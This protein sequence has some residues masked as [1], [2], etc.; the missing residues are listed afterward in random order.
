MD[1]LEEIRR[2]LAH[3]DDSGRMLPI[4]ALPATAP[5]WVFREEDAFGVAVEL[6]DDRLVSEA[7]A[8]ARL[9]TTE[10]VIDGAP[11]RLLRLESSIMALR[12]EFAVV[13]AQMV[14]AGRSDAT[15]T[16]L[17]A[18][19]AAWWER[20]RHL[21]GN[22]VTSRTSYDVLAELLTFERL[23]AQGNHVD[24]R[25]PPGGAVDLVTAAGGY[26]VKSTVSRYDSRIHVSGQFQ[27]ALADTRPLFLVHYRFEPAPSGESINGVCQRLVDAGIRAEVLDDLL[28]R[29]GLEAGCSAR[30]ETFTVLEARLYVVDAGFPRIVPSSF[31]GGTLPPGVVH[32]E[33]QVDLSGLAS[34]PF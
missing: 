24:W 5:A 30:N 3:L 22:A 12:N 21:L 8:G 14:E 4:M 20:W 18:D 17:L 31:A 19:P 15:R 13:C 10:R 25:G 28:S 33:Y 9:A 1:L 11:R 27:L 32:V 2:G 23:L 26:E 34:V 6:A 7:F 16:T 29:C